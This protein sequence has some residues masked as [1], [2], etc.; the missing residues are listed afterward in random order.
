MALDTP[1]AAPIT[2]GFKNLM[3]TFTVDV[4]KA[5]NRPLNVPLIAP[6]TIASSR[7]EKVE[8]VAI[9]VELSNGCVGWGEAPVLP[10]VT[11]EDQSIAMAKA[12]EVC[13]FLR[14]LPALTLGSMLEEI[15][16][17]LPGHQFA[18][19]SDININLNHT[20]SLFL[21]SACDAICFNLSLLMSQIVLH[22]SLK[23]LN[24][25]A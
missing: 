7:L 6:F 22:S 21:S 4:N 2:F 20:S 15:E 18:S 16:G 8:N 12:G 24:S 5:E 11:A 1:A 19:V 9:R 17:V 13:G 10:F 14:R 23:V 25:G 3:E